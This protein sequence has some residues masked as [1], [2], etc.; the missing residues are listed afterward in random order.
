[1]TYPKDTWRTLFLDTYSIGT[2]TYDKYAKMLMLMLLLLL[3]MMMM[4]MMVMMMIMMMMMIIM[5]MM[6][7]MNDDDDDDD[8]D[9]ADD[10]VG[11]LSRK[12][13]MWQFIALNIC[14]NNPAATSSN[15]IIEE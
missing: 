11:G 15:V 12:L 3:M 2:W 9:D 1:M 5:M 14:A 7:M 10:D 8:D 6:M 4:L 13:K